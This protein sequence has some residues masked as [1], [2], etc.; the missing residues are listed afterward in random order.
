[1]STLPPVTCFLG[2]QTQLSLALN[3]I[4]RQ[5]R[6][7]FAKAGLSVVPSRIATPLLRKALDDRDRSERVAEFQEAT[8]ARPVFLS[9][10]NF[11]GPPQAGLHQ[12]EM[13]PGVEAIVANL[14]DLGDAPRIV[15]A[16]DRL[17]AF[18]LA[19]G[20]EPLERK[21]TAT[22][23]E[24]LYELSWADLAQEIRVALPKAELLVLAPD[25]AARSGAVLDRL[26][27]PAAHILPSPEALLEAVISATGRAVLKQQKETP[28]AGVLEELYA[29]FATTPTLGEVTDRLGLDKVTQDLLDQRFNEDLAA[30][31]AM[32]KTEVL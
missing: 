3:N 20:S 16:A 22:A 26:F 8:Q 23:W 19:S 21:V 28:E 10:V 5:H 27:G 13:F 29:S 7:A 2:P 18:F 30:I 12:R 1:M 6:A 24:T 25:T 4:I 31:T 14:G 15:M 11:F 32:P 9:A 17:P